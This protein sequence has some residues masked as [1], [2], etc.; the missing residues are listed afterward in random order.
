MNTKKPQACDVTE[1]HFR[2]IL[3]F[4][5]MAGVKINMKKASILNSIYNVFTA[6][7]VYA[8]YIGMYVDISEHNDDLKNFMKTFLVLNWLHLNLS[9]RLREVERLLRL[10]ESFTSED[11]PAND[12]DTG[13]R[14]LAGWIPQLQKVMKY[15]FAFVASYHL[16]QSGVRIYTCISHELVFRTW[17]PFDIVSSPGYE[18]THLIWRLRDFERL[19][20]LTKCLTWED[21]PTRDPHTGHRTFAGWIPHLQKVVTY[22]FAFVTSFHLVQSG[23]RIYISHELVFRTWYP[24]DS[25]S[26]P[27]YELVIIMQI[28]ASIFGLSVFFGFQFLYATLI[29]VACSQLQKLRTN[30]LDIKQEM[31][32]SGD[33]SG[34]DGREEP[35]SR[36]KDGFC[37]MQ[38]QLNECVRHH[39]AILQ[40]MRALEDTMNFL[41]CGL[42]LLLLATLCFVSFSAVA[43]WGDITDLTQILIIYVVTI[44]YVCL[45]CALGTELTLQAERVRD[46]A[47]GCDWVGTPVPFQRCLAFIIATANKEFTL[48]AG[49]FVPVSNSTMMSILQESISLFMF[50]L[51]MKDKS[52][53]TVT[54]YPIHH[55]RQE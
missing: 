42:L 55:E 9:W 3:T 38:T 41:L 11:Q 15:S 53:E 25:V 34:S 23:L 49:K 39:Q 32:P 46:A 26:S 7:N 4:L 36:S 17:Q 29:M 5:R 6:I 14:T 1:N 33:E 16:V 48:T 37:R 22:S 19:L 30:L 40:Y 47:W 20:R 8:L 13:H 50:L 18:L 31:V 10:T 51:T 52:E 27:G 12:P 2:V 54:E 21:Q 43:S 28:F 35:V 44:F 24:F 45:F